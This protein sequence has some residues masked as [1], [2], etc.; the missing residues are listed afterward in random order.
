MS[1]VTKL[2]IPAQHPA[3]A[4]HFPGLPLLPG[5]VLLD[6]ALRALEIAHDLAGCRWQICGTKFLQPV[7]PGDVLTLEHERAENG[8]IRFTIR[9]ATQPV[10]AGILLPRTVPPT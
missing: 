3:F 7:R 8:T 10:A 6:E 9:G 4:G 1:T 2:E 5:V